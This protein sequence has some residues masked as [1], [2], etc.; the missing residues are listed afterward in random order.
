MSAGGRRR[1][2]WSGTKTV[3]AL[4][5][6]AGLVW[7]GFEIG[8]TLRGNPKV[9]SAAAEEMPVKEVV[10]VTDGVLNQQWMMDTLALPK[11]VSLMQLDLHGLQRRVLATSQ[12]RT[13]TLTRNFPSTL[14]VSISEY[15]PI[16]RV[17]AQVGVAE[18]RVFL[19]AREGVVFEGIG[20]DREMVSTLPWLAGVQLTRKD[21]AFGPIAH[22]ETVA[23]LLAKAKLEAEHLYRTWQV[24]SLARFDSDGEIE[25]QA[26]DVE[27]IVF[28]VNDDFFRQL[29]RLDSLL[30]AARAKTNQRLREVNLAIGAQVPVTFDEAQLTPAAGVTQ[31][32]DRAN[33]GVHGDA[34]RRPAM[35]A[36]SDFQRKHSL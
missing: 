23:D 10:L 18:P 15:S 5:L 13:A 30:D 16:A 36:F 29:A 14:T 8:A 1:M 19:V 31:N 6:L 3:G 27:R 20:F 33:G 9:L 35:R 12:V 7:G 2:V 28:G 34:A 17:M 21:D 24:V 11:K 32:A 26:S 25:V 4:A 22:M